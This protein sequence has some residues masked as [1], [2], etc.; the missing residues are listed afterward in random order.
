MTN[1]ELLQIIEQAAR[2]KVT[3]LDLCKK[4]LTI[5]LPEIGQLTNLLKDM[6]ALTPNIHSK[7]DFEELLDAIAQRLDE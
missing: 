7:S 4:G 5:L 1:E 2:D 3:K 6:N